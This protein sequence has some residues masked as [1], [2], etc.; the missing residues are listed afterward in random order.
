MEY[1]NFSG[2][3]INQALEEA[4]KYYEV[5]DKESIEYEIL[6]EGSKGIL[7]LFGAK[8]VIIKAKQKDSY[9]E[10]T[11]KYLEKMFEIVDIQ[12]Y[13]MD[14][15][16]EENSL[17][18]DIKSDSASIFIGRRGEGL[19][20]LQT[21]VS[22]VLNN[23]FKNYKK[24]IIDIE[25]YREKRENSLV[26]FAE[27]VANKVVDRKRDIKLEPMSPYERKIIHTAL[28]DHEEISTYSEGTD[29]YRRVVVSYK[30]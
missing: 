7:G 1:K 28:Q 13:E 3:D 22:T 16:E 18:V 25:N 17:Y 8:D 10:Y 5:E 19:R 27:K 9:E 30:K 29:P 2:K 6:D 11:R 12:D 15:K 21:I 20:S 24:V 26:R 4:I 23:K 14:I